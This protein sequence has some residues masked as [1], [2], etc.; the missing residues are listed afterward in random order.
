MCTPQERSS[1]KGTGDLE[2]CCINFD[3]SSVN[4]LRYLPA[5]GSVEHELDFFHP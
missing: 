2:F 5:L 1:R 4:I 3:M